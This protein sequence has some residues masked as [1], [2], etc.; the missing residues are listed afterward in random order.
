MRAEERVQRGGAQME[1]YREVFACA[2]GDD[3]IASLLS[4]YLGFVGR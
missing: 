2:P 3:N 4:M 1:V